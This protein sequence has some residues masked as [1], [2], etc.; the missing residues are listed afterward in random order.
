MEEGSLYTPACSQ[1]YKL[2]TSAS[3]L[4]LT[5][6]ISEKISHW[7]IFP[8]HKYQKEIVLGIEV[9]GHAQLSVSL[10]LPQDWF[11]LTIQI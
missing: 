6:H 5:T 2:I 1:G 3:I 11:T 8:I 7:I 9:E 10:A 4:L